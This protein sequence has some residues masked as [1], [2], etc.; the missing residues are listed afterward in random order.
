[1]AE[2]T[3]LFKLVIVGAENT[4]KTSLLAAYRQ[5]SFK[6]QV[7]SS[8]QAKQV[9]VSVELQ[10]VNAK[11]D[12]T[13]FDL[14][15]KDMHMGLNR[16]YLRD[17]NAALI[18]FDKTNKASLEKAEQWIK[19]LDQSGPSDLLICLAATKSDLVDKHQLSHQDGSNFAKLHK[20]SV[21]VECSA[22]TK[23]NLDTLFNKIAMECY[24]QRENF[25]QA[26][27]RKTFRLGTTIKREG[28]LEDGEKKG[29][30]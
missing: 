27:Q 29:C 22:K 10:G 23:E 2:P 30:C 8:D 19:E 14:P 15:G 4:G 28:D 13:C 3:P 11:V 1:M 12:L 17:T 16:M 7:K 6:A 20:I 25:E 26:E 21:F 5:K 9:N 18:V 24:K